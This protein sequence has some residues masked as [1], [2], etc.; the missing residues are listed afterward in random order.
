MYLVL[1]RGHK[2]EI[3]HNGG[4]IAKWWL[5]KTGFLYLNGTIRSYTCS[6][7]NRR[8]GPAMLWCPPFCRCWSP[9]PWGIRQVLRTRPFIAA[10]RARKMLGDGTSVRSIA[11]MSEPLLRV[12]QTVRI[13]ERVISLFERQPSSTGRVPMRCFCFTALLYQRTF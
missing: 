2:I 5:L 13:H 6:G 3:I 4:V 11:T 7:L 12:F 8:E 10:T 1:V 9:C